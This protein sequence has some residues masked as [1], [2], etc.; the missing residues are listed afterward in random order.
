MWLPSKLPPER[1]IV[2][3]IQLACLVAA[4]EVALRETPPFGLRHGHAG[5]PILLLF[6]VWH[7]YPPPGRGVGKPA[8]ALPKL[9]CLMGKPPPPLQPG[10]VHVLVFWRQSSACKKCLPQIEKMH[11]VCESIGKVHFLF[12]CV[13]ERAA[14][15]AFA[16]QWTGH[17]TVPMLHDES[18]AAW[19]KYMV[20]HGALS[21][22][23]AFVV[24]ERGLISWHGNANQKSALA[25]EIKARV[26]AVRAAGGAAE[27]TGEGAASK[28]SAKGKKEG[29]TRK[30]E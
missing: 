1:L 11:R 19:D 18:E 20:E 25:A 6:Y 8:A 27:A 22:P 23:H 15:Q 29:K 10:H 30:A 26:S 2:R 16:K 14:L 7:E 17:I 4:A 3:L 13:G 9:Q 12:I 28:P 5:L 21:L 24:N